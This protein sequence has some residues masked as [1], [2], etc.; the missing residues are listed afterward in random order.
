MKPRIKSTMVLHVRMWICVGNEPLGGY[1]STPKQA[2]DQW[3]WNNFGQS[4]KIRLIG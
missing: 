1:G 2:Y 3:W 4:S